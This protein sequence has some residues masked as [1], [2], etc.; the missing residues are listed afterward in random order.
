MRLT[1]RIVRLCVRRVRRL[2]RVYGVLPYRAR[3]VQRC[4]QGR[5]RGSLDVSAG[6]EVT[7]GIWVRRQADWR[8]QVVVGSKVDWRSS[9]GRGWGCGKVYLYLLCWWTMPL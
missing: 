6:T 3:A 5:S 2:V 7:A 1:V 9:S 4:E 8:R